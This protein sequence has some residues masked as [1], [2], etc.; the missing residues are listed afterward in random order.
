ME[1]K[2][3]DPKVENLKVEESDKTE[4]EAGSTSRKRDREENVEVP[5]A[6]KSKVDAEA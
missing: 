5:E 2:E 4:D 3:L 6:K 1:K